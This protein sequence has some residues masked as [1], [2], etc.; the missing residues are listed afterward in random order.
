M[1]FNQAIDYLVI[2]HLTHDLTADGYQVGGTVAYSAATA[3]VLGCRAAVLT[4]ATPDHEWPAVLPGIHVANTPAPATTT[5]ENIYTP[6]GRRQ[7]ILAVANQLSSADVPMVWQQTPIVHLGP[8]AN[9]IDPAIIALFDQSLIGLTPQG[10]LRRWSEDGRVYADHWATAEQTLPRAAAVIL[11][12]EDLLDEAMLHHYLQLSRLLV[13]TTGHD[14]CTVY[15]DGQQRDIPPPNVQSVEETGAGDIFATA[16]LVQLR[17]TP[18][19]PWQAAV[20]ANEVASASIT[21]I[22]LPAKMEAIR[23]TLALHPS[24]FIIHPF[25]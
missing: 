6:Q 13:L 5:F 14:G 4:S 21:Q 22:G 19:D 16:F 3:N 8:V 15:W 18:E 24:S 17:Q 25:L 10:W 11:S 7:R 2:G 9:E 20:F 12:I 1:T 23:N